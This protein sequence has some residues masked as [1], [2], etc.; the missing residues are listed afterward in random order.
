[1][2]RLRRSK[3]DKLF[4]DLVRTIAGWSCERCHVHYEPPTM[5]LHCSHFHGRARKSVR[6]DKENAS[7]LCYGCHQYF[8]SN[9]QEHREFFLKRLGAERLEVLDMRAR[10]PTKVNEDL[11]ALGLKMELDALKPKIIGGR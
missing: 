1:M 7:A 8:T 11:I 4:S 6:W 5:A 2:F 9:P 3:A 10:V